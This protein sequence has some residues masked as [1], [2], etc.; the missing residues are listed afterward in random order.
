MKVNVSK[1]QSIILKLN[2]AISY[3]EI[4]LFVHSL[5]PVS[6]VKFLGVQIGEGLSF[7]V[8]VST[9]C[10]KASHQISAFCRIVK[11]LTLENC[12]SNFNDFI[13]FNFNY[14]HFCS[15]QSWYKLQKLHKQALM[16][17][18]NDYS[19]SYRDLLDKVSKPT[20]L[21]FQMNGRCSCVLCKVWVFLS[22]IFHIFYW[23]V[24]L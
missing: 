11:Y 17:V 21:Y 13:A 19:S 12:M 15:K 5:K 24:G 6:S 7:D 8:H 20:L 23:V 3:V 16:V 14:C 1:F 2:S 18:L 9:L 10:A 4:N 22:H